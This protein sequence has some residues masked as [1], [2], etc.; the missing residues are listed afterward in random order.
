MVRVLLP[1]LYN[2]ERR[3]P[4]LNQEESAIFYEKG[5][6]PAIAAIMGPLV[7][8]WPPTYNS[9]MFRARGKDGKLAFQTKTVGNW[10]VRRIGD[11][12]RE[13]LSENNVPWGQGLVFLH[14]IRGVKASNGHT[15][16]MLAAHDALEELLTAN[17]I[18][19][20]AHL[21]GHWWVDV[22][23]EISSLWEECLA[24]RTDSHFHVIK[25]VLAIPSQHAR[26]IT[27]PGS[28]KYMRDMTS[29]LTAV[30][31]CRVSPGIRAQGPFN[32]LY[33]QMYM[34]DKSI[35]YRP[36]GNHFGKFLRGQD[37]LRGR[38]DNYCH[39]LYEVYRE[40]SQKNYSLARVEV[41]VPL[42]EA[43]N[44]LLDIDI[45]V[46]RGGLVCFDPS[47]WW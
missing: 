30:S 17:D 9:E 29:H 38:A 45:E 36:D 22:G 19:P 18:T 2:N 5:L 42:A 13:K 39:D 20:D 3:T 35:T 32:A 1:G 26:R 23:L 10:L 27:Q 14:Q 31:G 8:E 12:L 40:A 28:S 44:I 21:G 37:I 43:T 24:W 11:K 33:F 34:T 7:A 47:I 46:F 16:T 15:P 6:R 41:R 4:F 25:N